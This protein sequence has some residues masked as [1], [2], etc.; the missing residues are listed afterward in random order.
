MNPDTTFAVFGDIHGRIALMLYLCQLWQEQTGRALDGVLQCGDMGAFPDHSRLDRA[1][2]RHAQRDPDELAYKA[3]VNDTSEARRWLGVEGPRV[4]WCRGNHEDFEHLALFAQPAPVDRYGRLWYLPDG[5][6]SELAGVRVGGFGGI[7]ASDERGFSDHRTAFADE[8]PQ[9]L[10]THAGPRSDAFGVG[11]ELL[12]ELCRRIRPEVH[13]FGHHHRV[14]GPDPGPGG[15]ML[16]GLEHLDWTRDSGLKRGCWGILSRAAGAWSFEF[17]DAATKPWVRRVRFHNWR[18]QA[19]YSVASSM[20]G[21][22]QPSS[23]SPQSSTGS[24]SGS[25][26]GGGGMGPSDTA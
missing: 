24:G 14:F 4:L 23:S 3:F 26:G 17:M 22:T 11:S 5:S 19:R 20:R 12:S 2:K 8:P 1:T 21:S 10:L 6:T 15:S 7:A 18:A 16:V 9:I 13:L 25:G